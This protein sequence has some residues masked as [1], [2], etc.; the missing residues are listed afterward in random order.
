MR[1]GWRRL[2]LLCLAAGSAIAIMVPAGS[3]GNREGS[4]EAFF[5]A[6]PGPG[7]VTYGEDIA[8][9]AT[10]TNTGKSTFT[11]VIFRMRIPF[12]AASG[13]Q[14]YAEATFMA[15][16]CP[17]TPVVVSTPS[18]P[19]WTCDYGKLVP[20]KAG[21]PQLVLTTV[22]RVPTLTL[23]GGC[24][25]ACLQTNGRWT[26]KEGVN[27][28]ADPNDAF[29]PGGVPDNATLLSTSSPTEAG[30]YETNLTPCTDPLGAGNL[31]TGLALDPTGNPV[32]TTVCLPSPIPFDSVNLGLSTTLLEGPSQAG[33]PGHPEFGR[34]TVCI[35]A[36]GDICD[37]DYVPQ[38]FS[39]NV[40]TV[41]L[42]GTTAALSGH[43]AVTQIFH[44]GFLLPSCPSAD[45]NGCVVSITTDHD[46]GV[47]TA[48]VE[49]ATN[50][51]FNW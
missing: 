10:F 36:L 50:G 28:V 44:N 49:A 47:V 40:A 31:H 1:S 14:P 45:P 46:S 29:P 48:V 27:D 37:G 21:T 5:G 13:S 9:R 18:G 4:A 2:A 35:A 6:V 39:P 26:I 25:S 3:A 7:R 16:T 8:Y 32:S 41:V 23:P 22:W 42:R 38:D 17:S 51:H 30:G 15:S 20:G 19:E 24:T 33:D 11:H 12:V 43:T 34:A